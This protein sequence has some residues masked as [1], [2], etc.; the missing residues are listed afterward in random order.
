MGQLI[1]PP[2]GAVYLD[3]DAII[4]AVEK[5]EPYYSLLLPLLGAVNR[6]VIGLIGSE[7]LLVE[8]LVKPVEQGDPAL[9]AS[10][11]RFLTASR[12]MQL[13]PIS[14][15][16]LERALKLRATHRVRTPDA[17]HAATALIAGCTLFATNDPVFRRVSGLRAV[18]LD[19]YV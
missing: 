2:S 15:P 17:I 11:R 12:E 3:A 6:R 4:Y 13:L 16:I 14:R 8:T 9:E 7:L 19:D 10:F 1:V 18:I 5:I